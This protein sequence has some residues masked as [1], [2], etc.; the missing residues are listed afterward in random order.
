LDIAI[1][2]AQSIDLPIPLAGTIFENT[3][4]TSVQDMHYLKIVG[5]YQTR[6]VSSLKEL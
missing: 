6:T 2:F 1:L 4:S 5:L 3:L